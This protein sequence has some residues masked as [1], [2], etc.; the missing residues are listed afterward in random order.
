MHFRRTVSRTP[1]SVTPT[2]VP[3]DRVVIW[4][5]SA[6]Y[7]DSVFDRPFSFDFRRLRR[8]SPFGT[9]RHKCLGASLAGL[10]V[11]VF[12]EEFLERVGE[13]EVT[14]RP[15]RLRSNFISGIKHLPVEVTTV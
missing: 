10:E 8:S 11:R 12:F 1:G 13:F 6:N 15:D 2:L 5:T 9:G 7:D 4:Y 3:G 14:G